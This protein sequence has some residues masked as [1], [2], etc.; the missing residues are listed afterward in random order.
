MHTNVALWSV[1]QKA[2]LN[3][4]FPNNRQWWTEANHPLFTLA[5]EQVID[6]NA[7]E[8]LAEV[9]ANV[10]RGVWCAVVRSSVD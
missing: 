4:L 7:K 8:K 2:C 6:A 10:A 5:A 9:N 1:A 3:A